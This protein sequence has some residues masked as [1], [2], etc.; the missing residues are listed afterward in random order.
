MTS[1]AASFCDV[2]GFLVIREARYRTMPGCR[3][4]D[5]FCRVHFLV[6]VSTASSMSLAMLRGRGRLVI[7]LARVVGEDDRRL[8]AVGV[9]D[10]RA[11]EMQGAYDGLGGVGPHLRERG[12]DALAG[13]SEP[14]EWIADRDAPVRAGDELAGHGG[15]LRQPGLVQAERELD[16]VGDA[17]VRQAL[18]LLV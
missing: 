4:S 18:A 6:A 11:R 10:V 2:R 3:S 17:L 5:F 16:H 7:G 15:A 13:R 1:H 9:L 12:L 14:A 8:A